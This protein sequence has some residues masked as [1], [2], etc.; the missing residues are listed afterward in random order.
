MCCQQSK[1]DREKIMFFF[2]FYS[3][4][5]LTYKNDIH[6]LQQLHSLAM[7]RGFDAEKICAEQK[8]TNNL[9]FH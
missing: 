4:S 6:K 5:E 9:L 2:L 8:R 1:N 3:L 7:P